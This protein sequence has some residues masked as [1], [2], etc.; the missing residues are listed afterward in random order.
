M[1]ESTIALQDKLK[2]K[3]DDIYSETVVVAELNT[4]DETSMTFYLSRVDWTAYIFKRLEGI[5]AD[6]VLISL[7]SGFLD[8]RS[9]D[10][11]GYI[12]K[13]SDKGRKVSN[14]LDSAIDRLL[15]G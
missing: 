4:A 8:Y 6:I 15:G 10:R 3:Y 11:T 5:R 2:K 7:Q 13:L 14:D 1:I 12:Y 9:N